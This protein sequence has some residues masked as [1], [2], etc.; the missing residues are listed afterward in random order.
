MKQTF[1]ITVICLC[2]IVICLCALN[3]MA[4]NEAQDSIRTQEIIEV[5][6]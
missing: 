2:A 1:I 4:Q 5:L 6:S 3:V